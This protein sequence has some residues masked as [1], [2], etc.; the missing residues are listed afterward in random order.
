MSA[1][2]STD[3]IFNNTIIP[4]SQIFLTRKNVFGLINLKPFT[5]GHVLICSRRSVPKLEHLT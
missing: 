2:L 3:I 4:A 5:T 1:K